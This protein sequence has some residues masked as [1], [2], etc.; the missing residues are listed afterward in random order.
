MPMGGR[1]PTDY[2]ER[3]YAGVLGK[4]I[5]VY[6]GRPFEG[7]SYDRIQ[8]DLGE[9]RYYVNGHAG[10]DPW[11]S[12]APIVQ[13][14][15]DII[16]TF[17]FVRA[18]EDHNY[19]RDVTP[20]Q[21]GETWLNYVV[22]ERSTFWWGGVGVAAEHAAYQ[23]L[24]DGLRAPESGSAARNGTVLAE[25]IGAQIFID[26]WAMVAPGDPE[27][28]A[29][30]ARRAAS[31]S[32]DGEAIHA[33]QVV[34]AMEALAFV[35]GDLDA[36]IDAAVSLI[37]PDSAIARAIADVREWH[38]G[39]RDW[40][41]TCAR[42]E[43]E[44]GYAAHPGNAPVVPNH[45]LIHLALLYG[46]DDFQRSLTIVNTSGWDTDCNSGN[47]G[48]LLGI[49]NGLAGIEAGP[50]WRRPVAD[51]ML[52]STADGGRAVTDAVAEAF[53][54]VDA[55][56]AL[57]GEPPEAPNGR[58]RFSFAFPGSLQGFAAG[59][60]ALRNTGG[61]LDIRFRRAARAV[62]PT[63][64]P[65]DAIGLTDDAVLAAP[66]LH[67]VG[68]ALL[69][70][71]TLYPGHVLTARVRADRATDCRLTI[72]V[73]D[74][75]DELTPVHGPETRLEP[76][77]TEVLEWTVP[78][79][80]GQP[81]AQVGIEARAPDGGAVSLESLTW[82]G[83]PDVTFSRPAAGGTM[84]RRAWVQAVDRFDPLSPE[85][86]RLIQNRGRGLLI[87]G[88]REWD[89]YEVAAPVRPDMAIAAGIA[90]RVQGLRRYYA[91]LLY[92]DAV[93]L[94]KMLEGETVLAEAPFERRYGASY[95]LR[96]R[97]EGSAIAASVG[98]LLL[99]HRDDDPLTGGAAAFVCE[100]GSLSSER[101]SVRRTR[102]RP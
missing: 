54:I 63:F 73:Y 67:R 31:V 16:G 61:A 51:R 76:G 78:D 28:A 8:R 6:L 39:E 18:L 33:A 9:I 48:C 94:V 14:D 89:D 45:A 25:Q 99:R 59:D 32:H 84:W 98:D 38:A 55:G 36:L 47:V 72:G 42:I 52:L 15:D 86:Y 11:K 83:A 53:R 19:P 21:I 35:E 22:E 82:S 20:A 81:V 87:Q 58:P 41:R 29:D 30:L 3:V 80:G 26:G 77:G 12:E 24:K 102:E 96:L 27:L 10:L 2:A 56:R 68:Y 92:E 43:A 13:T 49:K 69:A 17:T 101:L 34:A 90:A 70:S 64:T 91:L 88:T 46:D 74:D 44:H 66:W 50:D 71:P 23:A 93:R 4:I 57:A 95:D 65:P 7:W 97:V 85:P 5:G 75:A 40:R 60:A 1:V 100:Q 37:P 79:T 62:T